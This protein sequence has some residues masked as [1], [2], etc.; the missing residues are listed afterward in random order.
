[1]RNRL[2]QIRLRRRRLPAHNPRNNSRPVSARGGRR[3]PGDARRI[4]PQIFQTVERA[5]VAMEDV[6]HRFEVIEHDPLTRR[7]TVDGRRTPAVVLA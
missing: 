7:E 1:M 3:L 4:A 2:G 6:D 5:F